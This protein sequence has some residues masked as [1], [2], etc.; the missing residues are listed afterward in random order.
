MLLLSNVNDNNKDNKNNNDSDD[1][2]DKFVCL[3]GEKHKGGKPITHD[4]YTNKFSFNVNGSLQSWLTDDNII[5]NAIFTKIFRCIISGP[6]ECGNTFL[7][8]NLVM[9]S[10]HFD[11]LYIIGPTG[12]QYND[13]KPENFEF[14]KDIKKVSATQSTTKIYKETHDI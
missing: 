7:L 10:K 9:T 2:F 11:K 12:D 14:S 4:I 5:V 3:F 1:D 13:V 8:K 6:S